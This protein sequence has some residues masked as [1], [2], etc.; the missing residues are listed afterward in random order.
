MS[1]EDCKKELIMLPNGSFVVR[2]SASDK[3]AMVLVA[4]WA[5]KVSLCTS[6]AVGDGHHTHWQNALTSHPGT[7]WRPHTHTHTHSLAHAHLCTYTLPHLTPPLIS[8]LPPPPPSSPFS[9]PSR[10]H[11]HTAKVVERKIAQENGKLLVSQPPRGVQQYSTMIALLEDTE[12]AKTPAANT[13]LGG[14]PP[15][16]IAQS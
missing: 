15:E 9:L 1:R 13:L 8:P 6:T 10:A 12:A 3:G 14:L 7:R 2:E 11:A 4:K 16:L 5:D